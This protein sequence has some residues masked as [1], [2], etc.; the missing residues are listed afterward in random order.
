[1]E[2]VSE[3]VNHCSSQ[4]G[5]CQDEGLEKAKGKP[6]RTKYSL[7]LGERTLRE[8]ELGFRESRKKKF[9]LLT[10]KKK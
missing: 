5:G 10:G 9:E 3:G 1:M 7:M 2:L 6:Q 4:R 8:G